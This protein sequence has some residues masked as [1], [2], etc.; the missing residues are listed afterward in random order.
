[1]YIGMH[2]PKAFAGADKEEGDHDRGPLPGRAV[3][4]AY[5][6]LFTMAVNAA[7]SA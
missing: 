3:S 5:L 2:G 1:M 4:L 6:V 7:A